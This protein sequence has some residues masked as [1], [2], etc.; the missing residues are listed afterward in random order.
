MAELA[1]D[2]SMSAARLHFEQEFLNADPW[3]QRKD[4][5][6]SGLL[7]ALAPEERKRAITVVKERRHG[8][9]N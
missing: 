9:D 5:F 4:R 2:E 8:W 7:E 6:P 1:F 3:P